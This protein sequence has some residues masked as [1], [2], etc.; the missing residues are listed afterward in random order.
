[1]FK[2]LCVLNIIKFIVKHM[3]YIISFD[4]ATKS[5]A[6][7]IVYYNLGI[8]DEIHKLYNNYLLKKV[9]ILSSEITD[10]AINNLLQEYIILLDQVIKLNSEKIK[11]MYLSVVDLI[12]NKKVVET[13][14]NNF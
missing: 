6:T 9:Q 2:C 12:P 10:L 8:T 14:F 1:M 13:H 7:S 11:I 4:P 3:V 5:L